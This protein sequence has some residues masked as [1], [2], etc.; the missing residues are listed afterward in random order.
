MS[1]SYGSTKYQQQQE[2]PQGTTEALPPLHWTPTGLVETA[3]VSTNEVRQIEEQ[4]EASV[5][6]AAPLGLFGFAV[7]TFVAS[8][9][10]SNWYPATAMVAIIPAVLIF[11]GIAQFI[12]GLL[13]FNRGS[14]FGGTTFCSY[15]AGNVIIATFLWMQH[16]GMI[17]IAASDQAILGIGL[18]CFAY[19][20]FMLGIAALRA[21]IAYALTLAALIPGYALSAVPM[22]GGEA[23][24]GH[25]GGWFLAVSALLA[26]YAG[27]AVVVNSN[28]RRE[29]LPLGNLMK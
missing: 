9:V 6:E 11:A 27:G 15:G 22:V 3:Y 24:V 7:G 25:V 5:A 20:S 13:S 2:Q 14:T 26:F 19:I 8:M 12:A 1:V 23:F 17:P 10:I 18:F 29:V 16:A 4:R 21:N 28:W